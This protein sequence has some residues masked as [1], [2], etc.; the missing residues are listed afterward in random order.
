MSNT[1]NNLI[2]EQPAE[3]ITL[4]RL[5]R[6][7]IHNAINSI[8]WQ[9]FCD[10]WLQFSHDKKTRCII[11][12]GS[13][14]KSFCSGAD[15]KERKG[16]DIAAWQQIYQYLQQAMLA[17]IECPQ[18]IIAAVN[19]IAY[20][21]GLELALASDFIYA[22]EH[23]TFALPEVKLGIM[24]GAMGTQ[25][26]PRMLG[27]QRAQELVLTGEPF[28]AQQAYG[29]GMVNRLCSAED[30]LPA[31]IATAKKIAANAPL[32]TRNAKRALNHAIQA[33]LKKDYEFEVSTY[34]E[35][36]DTHDRVEGVNA[37]NEKRQAEFKGE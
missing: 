2:I 13:G 35:L 33:D 9:E 28:S 4:V 12:T 30:L 6:P 36:L 3:F 32:A 31:A 19:G 29:W 25:N 17:M 8:M 14:E 24:P 26:I 10:L 27:L 7:E 11:L 16:L 37:F 23:A 5:N 22:A 1:Y 15:L 18:P 20:G 34:L 21:G